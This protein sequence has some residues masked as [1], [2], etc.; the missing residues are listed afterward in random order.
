MGRLKHPI[1]IIILVALATLGLRFL[2]S[3][4]L[5]LP[6]AASAEAGPIDTLFNAHFWMIA[7]L[8][9]LI[10]VM[11]IYS[12]FVFRRADDDDSDGPHVH[13]NT[14][15]EIGWT[16]VPTFVVLG[17]GVWGAVILNEITRPKEGEMTV[18]VTGKQWIWSF[19]Y[20]EQEDVQS[21]ELVLPVNRTTVLKMNAEDVIHSFWVPEF[22]VKQDLVP[23]RE[24]TLRITPTETGA[25][26]LRCAEICGL[27]H[28]QMEAD[29]RILSVE[30]FDAWVAEKSAAPAFAEMTPEERGAYWA[31]AE[32]F[33][34]VACHSSD[35][36]PG[37]G[38]TWQGLYQR[39][40]QLTDGSTI[41]ADD[42]YIINSINEPNAQ[43]VVGFN[44]NIMPQN[45]LEQ[46][47]TREQEIE[48]AEAIDL[49][50]AADLI[51]YIKTLQ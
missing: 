48:A 14:R 13:S 43:I 31:S 32:G 25:Y 39:Q 7:F 3:Y 4:I 18:N 12:V 51:A 8:F 30:E 10:M 16:I 41:T 29:V 1:S 50:I 11:M 24:T 35:G 5:A 22:R 36:T 38:P 42:A 15:L 28:T 44:P 9:S 6:F 2:F 23:G 46:F 34:C 47:T 26:K 45:Y 21:G 27:N 19:A 20:P 37:V 33:G 49:D 17:F 40:E